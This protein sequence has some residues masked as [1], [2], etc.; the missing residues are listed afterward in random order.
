MRRG[1]VLGEYLHIGASARPD[2]AGHATLLPIGVALIVALLLFFVSR[3]AHTGEL[4]ALKEVLL[5]ALSLQ[6]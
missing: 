2:V 6:R 4:H 1:L 5:R 3:E